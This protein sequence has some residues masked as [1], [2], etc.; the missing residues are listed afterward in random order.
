MIKDNNASNGIILQRLCCGIKSTSTKNQNILQ[1]TDERCG[2]MHQ[3]FMIKR[4]PSL[5]MLNLAV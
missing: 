5:Y 4:C 3:W 1:F 2:E